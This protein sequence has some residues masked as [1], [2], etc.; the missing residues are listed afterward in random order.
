MPE[1]GP[2]DKAIQATK[3]YTTFVDLIKAFDIVSRKGLW[4]ILKHLDCPPKFV[5]MVIYLHEDQLARSD[6]E[7]SEPFPC[8]NGVKQGCVL[9]P[10]SLKHRLQHDAV[11]GHCRLR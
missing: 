3:L 4:L 9:A 7:L 6:S 8:S 11:A 10:D 5:E 1:S 2:G